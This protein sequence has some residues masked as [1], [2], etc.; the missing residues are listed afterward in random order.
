[1]RQSLLVLIVCVCMADS[2]AG[3]GG[4][5]MAAKMQRIGSL[6]EHLAGAIVYDCTA[7]IDGIGQLVGSLD[8]LHTHPQLNADMRHWSIETRAAL[9]TLER[10][11]REQRPEEAWGQRAAIERK[12][13]QCHQDYPLADIMRRMMDEYNQV[14]DAIVRG[15]YERVIDGMRVLHGQTDCWPLIMSW[16]VKG[17]GPS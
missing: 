16:S 4:N 13:D 17:Y 15:R 11:L 14:A 5:D 8:E 9:L 7:T 12:C 3:V 6:W 2:L 1:M 10:F